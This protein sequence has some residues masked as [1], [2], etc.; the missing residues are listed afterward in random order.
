[1]STRTI[2]RAA[3][4]TSIRLA[5]LPVD[6]AIGLLPA[7]RQRARTV[8][9]QADANLRALAAAILSD[10]VLREDAHTRYAAAEAR[11]RAADLRGQAAETAERAD[12]RVEERHQ[13]AVRRRRAADKRARTRR[14]T[15]GERKQQRTRQAARAERQRVQASR[16]TEAAVE[17]AIE[18]EAP[19]ARLQA[20]DAVVDAQRERDTAMAEMDEA[21]RLQSAAE[22]V[23]EDRKQD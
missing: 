14:E 4:T 15:A 10:D 13:E 19:Q 3:V 18:E 7:G 20:L 12:E 2:P 22:R 16:Q 9:D 8:V 5:R 21:R 23:K 1:M 6:L 17:Q 11:G